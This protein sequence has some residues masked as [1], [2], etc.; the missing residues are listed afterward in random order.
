MIGSNAAPSADTMSPGWE[1]RF[2][3]EWNVTPDGEQTRKMTGH[4]DNNYGQTFRAYLLVKGTDGSGA[5]VF[6]RVQPQ[7]GVLSPLGREH[8]D[9]D[10]LPAAERYAVT[11]YSYEE[12][13]RN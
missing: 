1:S 10:K 4:F 9:I 12:A 7:L 6:R 3:M 5:V 13:G 8:F 2:K 11:V